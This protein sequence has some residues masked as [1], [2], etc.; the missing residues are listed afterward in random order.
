MG[1]SGSVESPYSASVE[2]QYTAGN[3]SGTGLKT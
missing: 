3:E 1:D 2:L